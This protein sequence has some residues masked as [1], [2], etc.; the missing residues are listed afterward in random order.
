MELVSVVLPVYNGQAY[1]DEA[2][3]S[4][5][6]QSYHNWELIIVND[7]STDNSVDI[8]RKWIERDKR[9]I[10]INN[11]TNLKLPSSL[12]VGFSCSRGEYLTWTSDDNILEPDFLS[13]MVNALKCG[14]DFV[15]SN[16]NV[17]GSA[18]YHRVVEPENKI[19]NYNVIGAS[20]LYRRCVYE[21]IGDYDKSLYLLEDYDYW[22]RVATK[23]R[24]IRVDRT[25]YNYRMHKNSLSSKRKIEIELLTANYMLAKIKKHLT[26]C[27]FTREQLAESCFWQLVRM[28]KIKK[29]SKCI[30]SFCIGVRC[31]PIFFIKVFVKFFFRG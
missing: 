28:A 7:C 24:M 26:D 2:I 21:T 31:E 5:V 17:F 15:Y 8:I 1:I 13:V 16:Y 14:A 4:I 20:F 23:F 11:S 30:E 29:Y 25:L 3:N 18:C 10:L 19:L 6:N 12:N 27:G 9:I 22:I